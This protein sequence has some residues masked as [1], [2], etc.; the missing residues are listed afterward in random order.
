MSRSTEEWVAKSDDTAIPP[1]VKLRVFDR[2]AGRCQSCSRKIMASDTWQ[3]DHIVALINGGENRE[4][5]LQCLCDWCHKA[6]TAGD[7]KQKATVA[8]KRSKVLGL[9]KSRNPVPGSRQSPWKR[10]FDGTVTRRDK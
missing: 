6:K 3:A 7:V 4:Q 8:R 9:K 2:A 10:S 5:N 1:R